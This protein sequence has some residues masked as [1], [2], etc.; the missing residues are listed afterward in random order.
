MGNWWGWWR[1]DG[2]GEGDLES[3][4]ERERLV[5]SAARAAEAEVEGP[6]TTTREGLP[7][8]SRECLVAEIKCYGTVSLPMTS[9]SSS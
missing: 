7:K 3:L 2:H 6:A 4:R 5:G 8:L 9:M 1:R